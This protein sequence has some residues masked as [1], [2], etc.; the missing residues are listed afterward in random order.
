MF[1]LTKKMFMGLLITIVNVSNHTKC[2]LLIN[3]KC[4]SQT[5]HSNEYS[6][7]SHYYL[8]AI[9]LHRCAGN[10]NTL[11]DLS[12]KVCIPNKAEDLNLTVSNRLQE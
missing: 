9:K 3:Q 4:M 6:Q 10:C 11:N 7:E 5:L 8:F 12:Y 2:M 1:G